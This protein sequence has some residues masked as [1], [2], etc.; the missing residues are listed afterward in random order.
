MDS[1][2]DP[3]F[4]LDENCRLIVANGAGEALI[5]Q[6]SLLQVGIGDAFRLRSGAEHQRLAKAVKALCRRGT[7]GAGDDFPLAGEGQSR[8]V[9]LLPVAQNSALAVKTTLALFMPRACALMV[10]RPADPPAPC[11]GGRILLLPHLTPAE[12]RLA[13]ALLDGGSLVDVAARLGIAY[14][15]VRAQLRGIFANGSPAMSPAPGDNLRTTMP[16]RTVE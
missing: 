5:R 15:T 7:G 8:T 9:S 1:L 2:L 11:A 14:G 16:R 4:L 10:L 3:A 12:Q 13:Q 6:E